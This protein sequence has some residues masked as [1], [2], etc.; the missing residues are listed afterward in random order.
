VETTSP[1]R[2]RSVRVRVRFSEYRIHGSIDHADR[3]I[4]A[5]AGCRPILGSRD[6]GAVTTSVAFRGRCRRQR[7]RSRRTGTCVAALGWVAPLLAC[8]NRISLLVFR[9][10]SI[11]GVAMAV[12]IPHV[13]IRRRPASAQRPYGA[14]TATATTATFAR[15]D[16]AYL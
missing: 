9:G 10:P 14:A 15:T 5:V 13:R 2:R 1:E 11:D 7:L 16:G 8:C 3:S 12:A 4:G 6:S